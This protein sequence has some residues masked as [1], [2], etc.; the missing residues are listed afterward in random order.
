MLEITVGEVRFAARLEEKRAPQTVAFF[1]SLL[2][3]EGRLAHVKW[4]GNAL[5]VGFAQLLQPLTSENATSFPRIGELLFYPGGAVDP[6][7][8][9]PYGP[10]FFSSNVG[11]LP[12][13]HFAT[14]V[15][16]SEHLDKIGARCLWD[17]AQPVS[18]SER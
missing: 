1:R 6:E 11:L 13:N 8:L 4:S 15:E 14:I 17:G 5:W 2:P 12:G 9:V 16:G 7:L 18:F 10:C 3:F